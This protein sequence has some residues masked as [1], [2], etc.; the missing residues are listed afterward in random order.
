M[1]MKLFLNNAVHCCGQRERLA[2]H[3]RAVAERA[4]SF[5][6]VFDCEQ[7]GRLMGLL[8]DFGKYAHSFQNADPGEALNHA[9][10]GAA[11]LYL[12]YGNDLHA[13]GN[14]ALALSTAIYGHHTCLP[15]NLTDTLMRLVEGM[16]AETDDQGR[17]FTLFGRMELRRA[18]I[19]MD[20]DNA[21]N[22]PNDLL[23][24]R[25]Y[26]ASQ[27]FAASWMLYTRMMYSCLIDADVLANRRE[28]PPETRG[29]ADIDCRLKVLER[30][31]QKWL[32]QAPDVPIQQLRSEVYE[33]CVTAA[34]WK[35]GL[36]SLTA[37][38]GTGKTFAT[39]AFALYH[40]KYRLPN[41]RIVVVLPD[42]A[43]PEQHMPLYRK[44]IPGSRFDDGV[45]ERDPRFAE[46]WEAPLLVMKAAV[47][48]ETLF[49]FEPAP[50]RKLHQLAGSVLIL[51]GVAPEPASARMALET[52]RALV[53]QYHCS[54]ILSG[55]VPFVTAYPLALRWQPQEIAPDVEKWRCQDH[56]VFVRWEL[57]RAISLDEIANRMANTRSC[58]TIV[59]RT[60]HAKKL[61][62]LLQ[63]KMERPREDI[64]FLSEDLCPA[65]RD[66]VLSRI[67]ERLA[68]GSSCR[69]VATP[70]V[71]WGVDLDF[72]QVYRSVAPLESLWQSAG[73][74]NRSG[75]LTRGF[76]TIFRPAEETICRT[77]SER[78]GA[79]TILLVAEQMRTGREADLAACS[80]HYADK[81]YKRTAA[82][83]TRADTAVEQLNFAEV[84][85]CFQRSKDYV[86]LV[87]PAPGHEALY[88][89][90]AAQAKKTGMSPELERQAAP[91]T[92]LVNR[93]QTEKVS[94]VALAPSEDGRAE[95]GWYLLADL[96]VYDPLTGL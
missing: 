94:C 57:Q 73:R 8:H 93:E 7:Q 74:C 4:A 96:A 33:A 71:E 81:L 43:M 3:S 45:R 85:A 84:N 54:V 77:A 30:Y 67:Q 47:F 92:V 55:N 29:I 35:P 64:F 18:F 46:R 36:F 58:C 37:P 52:L 69:L 44:L 24:R 40:V 68:Q 14:P 5:A 49:A 89:K 27:H 17:R 87:V 65:H 15:G 41:S 53:G 62:S 50:S 22:L 78:R 19:E 95:S 63:T 28:D 12:L 26:P 88:R 60:A 31:R 82:G 23:P 38:S 66:E 51:D 34:R 6:S 91:L 79:E 20:R 83:V 70:C 2:C 61:F 9:G 16:G 21:G 86:R 39:L 1:E 11:L 80:A 76:L 13:I 90:I 25:L 10:P 32:K 48:W 42:D 75:R 72:E 59:N 56:R